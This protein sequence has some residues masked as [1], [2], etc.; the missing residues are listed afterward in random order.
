MLFISGWFG[1]TSSTFRTE[2]LQY[3]EG[4]H[5]DRLENQIKPACGRDQIVKLLRFGVKCWIQTARLI[6]QSTCVHASFARS[7]PKQ[8]PQEKWLLSADQVRMCGAC[9]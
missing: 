6:L 1:C 9:C 8:F 7:V 4:I 5:W 2:R 3:R